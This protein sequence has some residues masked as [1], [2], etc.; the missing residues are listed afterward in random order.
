MFKAKVDENGVV[1]RFKARLDA[2]GFKSQMGFSWEETF[3][4]VI[5]KKSIRVLLALSEE[6]E[7]EVHLMDVTNAYLNCPV[8]CDVY[9]EQPEFYEQGSRS[10]FVCKL[11]KSIYGLPCASQDWNSWNC[12]LVR[13]DGFC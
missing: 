6:N 7:W 11:K 12:V 9:M 13:R 1:E 4:P 3:C 10:K 2:Q 8:S 5:K